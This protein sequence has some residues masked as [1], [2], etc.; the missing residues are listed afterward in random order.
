[1]AK[2][3]D[4]IVEDRAKKL[5]VGS[6][7]SAV[8]DMKPHLTLS[9]MSGR[10]VASATGPPMRLTPSDARRLA[11]TLLTV[12]EEVEQVSTKQQQPRSRQ[13]VAGYLP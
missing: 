8:F 5:F 4:P 2:R 1:M 9:L 10:S 7:K 11:M 3:A 13:W 12:A 6:W